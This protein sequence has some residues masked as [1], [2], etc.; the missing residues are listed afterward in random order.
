MRIQ[1]IYW[2]I[3]IESLCFYV[4]VNLLTSLFLRRRKYSHTQALQSR[5]TE[6]KLV[7]DALNMDERFIMTQPEGVV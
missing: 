2:K 6:R 4:E 3:A 5:G 1:S 7:R